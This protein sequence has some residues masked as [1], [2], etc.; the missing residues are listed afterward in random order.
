MERQSS[1]LPGPN[2]V[3]CATDRAEVPCS[4]RHHP[5]SKHW[6]CRTSCLPTA[7]PVHCS[8]AMSCSTRGQ[9]GHWANADAAMLDSCATE[10]PAGRAQNVDNPCASRG[11]RESHRSTRHA[12]LQCLTPTSYEQSHSH[13]SNGYGK[14]MHL[15]GTILSVRLLLWALGCSLFPVVATIVPNFVSANV[16]SI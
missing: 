7:P 5:A 11:S 14:Q 15:V 10:A 1:T 4:Q 2:G 13:A 9:V 3:G 6:H 16:N 8:L 12:C